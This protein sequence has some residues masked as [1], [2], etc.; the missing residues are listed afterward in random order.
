MTLATK[1]VAAH[2]L[3]AGARHRRA[4]HAIIVAAGTALALTACG[5]GNSGTSTTGIAT[6]APATAAPAPSASTSTHGLQRAVVIAKSLDVHAAPEST[7]ATVTRLS[8]RTPLGSPTVLLALAIRP[9]WVQVELPIRPNGSLGWVKSAEVRLEPVPGLIDVDLSRRR[10]VVTLGGRK[11]ASAPVAIGSPQN[12]T[13][14]GRFFVTDRVNPKDRS[15]P[16]GHFALG[17]SAHS[18]TLT[19]F[20]GADGQVGIHGTND[21]ASIGRA[22]SHGCIRVSATVADVLAQVPLGTPVLVH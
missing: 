13:P 15:G 18:D 16:Y 1:S 9:G 3:P 6:S 21:P 10:I 5:G 22:V 14:T 2:V 19:E 12:P 8:K 7:S 11:L 17:L 4:I 20:A